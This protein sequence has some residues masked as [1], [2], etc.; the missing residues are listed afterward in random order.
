MKKITKTLLGLSALLLPLSAV[1][2]QVQLSQNEGT[3]IERGLSINVSGTVTKIP[4]NG[5][6]GIWAIDGKEVLVDKYTFISG[7]QN[8]KVG[9]TSSMIVRNEYGKTFATRIN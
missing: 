1:A 3:V 4:A 9:D 7:S 6:Y 2:G 5:A 8:V